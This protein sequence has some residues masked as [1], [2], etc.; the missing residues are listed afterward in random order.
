MT[1]KRL[2]IDQSTTGTKMILVDTTEKIKILDRIDLPHEQIYPQKGWVEHNPIEIYK[3]VVV[4]FERILKKNRLVAKDIKSISITNQRESI[5]IW[6]KKT[7]EL[8]S[9]VMVWQCNRGIEICSE[10]EERGL[11]PLIYKKTGL[12]LDTYFSASKLKHF[13]DHQQLTAE[14]KENLAIGTMDAWLIW[15]LTDRQHLMTDVSNA[16]RTLLFNIYDKCWDKELT[17]IFNV[18]IEALPQVEHSNSNFGTYQEIPIVSVLADSQSA[19]LTHSCFNLGDTKATLGTGSS[20]LMNIGSGVKL[21]KEEAVVTIAWEEDEKTVYALEGIIRSF[22]DILNWLKDNLNLFK[23]FEEA[24]ELAFSLKNNDGVY[25]IPALEGLATPYWSPHLEATFEGMT[26]NTQ[27]AHLIRAGFEAM[28][29]QLRL[30][31][32]E[33]EES[34]EIKVTSLHVDGGPTKNEKFMQLVADITN[35]QIIVGQVEEAS[36]IGT[37]IILGETLEN[38]KEQSAT[39]EAEKSYE[40]EYQQWKKMIE[41]NLGGNES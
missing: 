6:D 23:T 2:V 8:H 35:K 24:S 17:T 32:D 31:L 19:L 40:K 28:A 36:A 1:E 9:N 30:V 38:S 21:K 29:F 26:R 33:F 27:R 25:F 11:K 10:L 14:Q 34:T 5:V 18:P 41:K 16:C 37:L 39:Y 7:G 4:L 12:L 22:G 20:L 3:N 15:N 13:F